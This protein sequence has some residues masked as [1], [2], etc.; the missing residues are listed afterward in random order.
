MIM[1]YGSG[2]IHQCTMDVETKQEPAYTRMYVIPE[3]VT[4]NQN[5]IHYNFAIIIMDKVLEDL[6]NLPDVLSDTQEIAK[7]IWTILYHSYTTEQGNFSWQ[8]V[9]DWSPDIHPFTE[10]FETTVGGWTM[11][12][13]IEVPFDYDQCT[14][15]IEF[16]FGFPQDQTFE[17]YRV[18]IDDFKKFADLHYQIN[19]YGFG[20]IHQ[21]PMDITTKKEPEYI[22]M[23]VIPET[24]RFDQNHLHI[25]FKVII[26]DKVLEDLTNQPDVLNDCLE[27]CK[28][29]FSKLY[30]SE[31]E[32]DWDATLEPF[33]ERFETTLGGWVLNLNIIQKFDFNRCVLPELSFAKG[34]TWSEW[35]ELWKNAAQQ[36]SKVKNPN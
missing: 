23:Y 19:S 9:G 34:M 5:H 20:D 21:L 22:R 31:Y 10:R 27:I 35:A 25:A 33:F 3:G 8:I 29:F 16:G 24:T 17:S 36:W 13:K 1:S 14:P 4:F 7:D 32:A 18:I 6:S 30:L 12:I 28:D 26:C 2:D 15:P 11:H